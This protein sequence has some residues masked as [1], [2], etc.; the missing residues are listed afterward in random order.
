MKKTILTLLFIAHSVNPFNHASAA[1]PGKILEM[2]TVEFREYIRSNERDLI[3][4]LPTAPWCGPCARLKP[5]QEAAA[6]ELG[7]ED[8]V[9]VRMGYDA[10]R[11][12]LQGELGIEA[13]PSTQ[14]YFQGKRRWTAT[15]LPKLRLLLEARQAL[16]AAR[17]GTFQITP[18]PA[19]TLLKEITH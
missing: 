8:I 15:G 16:T 12:F 4:L 7:N 13:L 6:I 18:G 19:G 11:P 1:G 5:E 2:N 14:V 3:V 17:S 9:L 10:N